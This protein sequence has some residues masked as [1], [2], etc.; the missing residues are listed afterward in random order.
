[1]LDDRFVL[2]CDYKK[3]FPKHYVARFVPKI[4]I[5][6]DAL[7]KVDDL[8]VVVCGDNTEIVKVE[9]ERLNTVD[10]NKYLLLDLSINTNRR[11]PKPLFSSSR[12]NQDKNV[13]KFVIV[14]DICTADQFQQICSINEDK[15]CH[16]V[17]FGDVRKVGWV[18]SGGNIGRVQQTKQFQNCFTIV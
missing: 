3:I 13:D 2:D 14:I 18:R 15:N 9:L 16:Y 17:R 4:L 1:M 7:K 11:V 6:I 12:P 5:N 10:L 8:F